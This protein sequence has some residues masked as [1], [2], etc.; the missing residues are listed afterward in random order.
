MKVPSLGL[1]PLGGRRLEGMKNKQVHSNGLISALYSLYTFSLCVLRN[2]QR[3]HFLPDFLPRFSQSPS[4]YLIFP[5]ISRA[6]YKCTI[7]LTILPEKANGLLLYNGR[8]AGDFI[9]LSLQDGFMVFQYNL[10]SGKSFIK[11]SEKIKLFTWH[12]IIASR[13]GLDGTLKVD[14]QALVYGK[15][16]GKYTSLNLIGDLYIGNH[17]NILGLQKQTEDKEGF[18]GCLSQLVISGHD[19]EIGKFWLLFNPIF[20]Y[21]TYPL[22][23]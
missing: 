17:D 1:A 14:N 3:F 20:I 8:I 12:T 22:L 6:L 11:S 18:T 16:E 4:S 2:C 23:N 7:E 19:I 13:D 9:S 5:K 21:F 10:G 15:S